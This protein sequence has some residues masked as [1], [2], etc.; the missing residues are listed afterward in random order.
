MFSAYPDILTIEELEDALQIG[1]ST[2]Y[3]LIKNEQIK[4]L[5]IGK[6][7]RI[8]KK[9][10]MDYVQCQCYNNDMVIDSPSIKE[11]IA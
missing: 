11:V 2:A 1:R 3:R 8:P 7:I 10:L 4:S 9:Y 5:R 6:I